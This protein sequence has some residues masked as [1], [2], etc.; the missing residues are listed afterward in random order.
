MSDDR[1]KDPRRDDDDEP[2]EFVNR[3]DDPDVDF[4]ERDDFETT[5]AM[6]PLDDADLE[7]FE[8]D[9]VEE[10]PTAR[11]ST[12]PPAAA[13]A[14]AAGGA[15]A[16]KASVPAEDDDDAPP[17]TARRRSGG[18]RKGPPPALLIALGVIVVVAGYIFWPRGGGVSDSGEGRA[19]VLTL[20]DTTAVTRAEIPVPRSSDVDLDTELSD[21]VPEE[22]DGAAAAAARA[23]LL[24]EAA[25]RSGGARE[26]AEPETAAATGTAPLRTGGGDAAPKTTPPPAQPAAGAPSGGDRPGADGAWAVQVGSFGDAANAERLAATLRDR[27]HRVVVQDLS[28]G[29][30]TV[31]RVWVGFFGTRAA[32]E[33]Y[34][35]AHAK[36]L[37]AKPYITHR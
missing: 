29:T 37:G 26:L 16:A 13:A 8:A 30:G 3:E 31:H 28:S 4:D 17:R 11:K 5:P 15:K 19:S 10:T 2:L 9:D 14:A 34:A 12:P 27:G 20:P 23:D 7:D 32:A 35:A 24:N 21:V 6:E 22:A 33:T 1:N 36:D 18:G 25:N